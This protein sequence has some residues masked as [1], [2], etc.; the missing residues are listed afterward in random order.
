MNIFQTAAV[1]IVGCI[2]ALTLRRE[3]P[4]IAM[5]VMIAAGAIILISAMPMLEELMSGLNELN[6]IIDTAKL[7][8]IIKTIAIAYAAA[9]SGSMC[10]DFG[11]SSIADK[12]E[13]FA[14]LTIMMYALPLLKELLDNV[15]LAL[16]R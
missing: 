8:I 11:Q 3:Q 2:L 14:K 5:A 1:G 7:E 4:V 12:I 16:G 15:S 13:L 9:F 10:R 6:D